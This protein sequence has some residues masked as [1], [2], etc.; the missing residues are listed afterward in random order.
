M[1]NASV[2]ALGEWKDDD[3]AAAAESATA[4]PPSDGG[5]GYEAVL[6]QLETRMDSIEDNDKISDFEMKTMTIDGLRVRL[7]VTEMI[8][9]PRV[10]ACERRVLTGCARG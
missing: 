3:D 5:A 6:S 9:V 7:Q 2:D 4:R 1:V 8:A 10:S